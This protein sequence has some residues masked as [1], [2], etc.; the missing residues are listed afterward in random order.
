M[1]NGLALA[2]PDARLRMRVVKHN[3]RVIE[4]SIP[5][6]RLKAERAMAQLKD[7]MVERSHDGMWENWK[8]FYGIAELQYKQ[9]SETVINSP[10]HEC[11]P[12]KCTLRLVPVVVYRYRPDMMPSLFGI[13]KDDP[14]CTQY[15]VCFTQT[16]KH[17][18]RFH[19]CPNMA[20]C[21]HNV[22]DTTET[23]RV[24]PNFFVCNDTGN[25][26]ICGSRCSRSE[27]PDV[28]EGHYVCELTGMRTTVGVSTQNN[29]QALDHGSNPDNYKAIM[30]TNRLLA[31]DLPRSRMVNTTVPPWER[32]S[33]I[34]LYR[35]AIEHI[36][37]ELLFSSRRQGIELDSISTGYARADAETRKALQRLQTKNYQCAMM[38][39][40]DPGTLRRVRRIA[41][42]FR[43]NSELTHTGNVCIVVPRALSVFAGFYP[44][45]TYFH[46]VP[47]R[48]EVLPKMRAGM[49]RCAELDEVYHVEH[50]SLI[51]S[52]H[53]HHCQAARV[54]K[55]RFAILRRLHRRQ[56]RVRLN[57]GLNRLHRAL[58]DNGSDSDSESDS[59]V[60][61]DDD[62]DEMSDDDDDEK[63]DDTQC[64]WNRPEWKAFVTRTKKVA[65]ALVLRVWANMYKYGVG[66]EPGREGL[67]FRRVALPLL[68]MLREGFSPPLSQTG[69]VHPDT[70]SMQAPRIT[71]VPRLDILTLLP[72]EKA[73]RNYKLPD[74][75]LGAGRTMMTVEK[76]IKGIYGR[77]AR[78]GRLFEVALTVADVLAETSTVPVSGNKKAQM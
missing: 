66:W 74:W 44:R 76:E 27:M 61:I 4:D 64:A 72:Q 17:V 56:K 7:L 5:L 63:P 54:K 28:H 22:R 32:E 60:Y 30:D 9:S 33:D 14:L 70:P 31:I 16:C 65:A 6:Q 10:N 68:Y 78:D 29:F 38:N 34:V 49:E 2:L 57:E 77:I 19:A 46:H 11:I 55:R 43:Y 62:D 35:N 41:P 48:P 67:N 24:L 15:H 21:P 12:G 20:L 75:S 23:T 25:V 1:D 58:D 36:C 52:E 26:H 53:C 50:Q 8:G 18:N 42:D 3:P 40:V 47:L 73:L 39:F 59:D 71:V 69:G 13:P 45:T 37:E 51:P